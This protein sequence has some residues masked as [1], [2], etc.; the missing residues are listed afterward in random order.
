MEK[1]ETILGR[2]IANGRTAEIFEYGDGRAVKLF[3]VGRSPN[4]IEY[5]I[6]V[7]RIVSEANLATPKMYDVVQ[8]SGR[9]GI[10]FERVD[11]I[12]MLDVMTRQPWMLG[13]LAW[14]F[15]ELHAAMHAVARDELPSQREQLEMMIRNAAR[16]TDE[17][18]ARVIAQLEQLPDGNAVCHGDFHPDNV[19]MSPRSPVI[20]D[21]ITAVR[22]NPLA[23]FARTSVLMRVAA[24][25]P[26]MGAWKIAMITVARGMFQSVYEREYFRLRGVT[27]ADIAPWIVPIAAARLSEGIPEEYNALVKIVE[28]K[29]VS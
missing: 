3:R 2:K 22:G 12:S 27:R 1:T 9:T 7:T 21:W 24:L 14:Q 25:L 19:M 26:S 10:V 16:L 29:N 6:K 18:K 23:D 20:I 15:A 13:R 4:A 5:E 8:V 17:T 11:G 28:G